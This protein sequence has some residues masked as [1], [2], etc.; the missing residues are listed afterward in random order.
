MTSE[1]H[2]YVELASGLNF[3]DANGQWQ[4]TREE[5]NA[6]PDGGL[7]AEFGPYQLRIANNLN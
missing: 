4:P 3:K 1:S 7:A 2:S 5:F 6:T